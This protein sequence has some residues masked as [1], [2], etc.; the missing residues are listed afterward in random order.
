MIAAQTVTPLLRYRDVRA[1]AKWLCAAFGFSEHQTTTWPTGEI[2][3]ISL[4]LGNSFVL[5]CPA[6]TVLEDL[7][8]EPG[9]VN[10]ANTQA[11]YLAI[12]DIDRH[13]AR[14]RDAGARIDAAPET[15]ESGNRIYVCRD[16]EGY[17]W[18]FGT[19]SLAALPAPRHARSR[20]AATSAVA[21]ALA[22][23][24]LAMYGFDRG[25]APVRAAAAPSAA[26]PAPDQKV[27]DQLAAERAQRLS[28]ERAA[29]ETAGTL[30]QERGAK[31]AMKTELERA[32][33]EL[34]RA[35]KAHAESV[36]AI[37]ELKSAK[38]AAEHS[39]AEARAALPAEREKAV[40]AG[41][42]IGRL[43]SEIGRLRQSTRELDLALAETR[44]A[45]AAAEKSD[46][47]ARAALTG[48]RTKAEEM[49]GTLQRLE[50]EVAH[51]QR[52][53][54][55]ADAATA[56]ARKAKDAADQIA[57]DI[58]TELAAEQ[59][60]RA[61]AEAGQASA[62]RK[63]AAIEQAAIAKAAE[64]EAR[65][66]TD[67]RAMS[68]AQQMSEALR[69]HILKRQGALAEMQNQPEAQVASAAY[70]ETRDRTGTSTVVQARPQMSAKAEPPAAV[71]SS[72]APRA[73]QA[74][75]GDCVVAATEI[76]P[77][78]PESAA[79]L[80][81]VSA[82]RLCT[83]A[84]DSAEPAKCFG[85]LMRGEVN[86]GG[87]TRWEPSSAIA[88]CAGTTSASRTIDCFGK[89]VDGGDPW[90]TAIRGCKTR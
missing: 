89:A 90:Q 41:Q 67:R 6:A 81:P 5:A 74:S 62:E 80:G 47:D 3:Y 20:I 79:I 12:D 37:G 28:I 57:H 33:A 15:D 65:A 61:D 76:K 78:K 86:W 66:A 19:Q 42:S 39:A 56:D 75:G 45:K 73:G 49:R 9:K 22:F 31:A 34:A 13:F 53:Q 4:R 18:T 27:L 88:L 35:S 14:A 8:V 24:G 60:R 63:I 32:Q 85:R 2:R 10:G 82:G 44:T 77:S 40:E 69:E 64:I 23:G 38:D 17:L 43:E 26:L 46:Q 55:Q 7:M 29:K 87:G 70:A 50:T 48:E 16:L 1:A 72:G 58:R 51:L 83:G 84:R 54:Q 36:R 68:E 21:V 71:R 11:S 30:E 25:K 59:R 52:A